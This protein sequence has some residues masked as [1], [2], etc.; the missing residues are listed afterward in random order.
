MGKNQV[1]KTGEV[2]IREKIKTGL[3]EL[4]GD[5]ITLRNT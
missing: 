2:Q 3:C 1:K 5:K 4:E